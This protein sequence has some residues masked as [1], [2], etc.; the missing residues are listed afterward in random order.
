[1]VAQSGYLASVVTE[2]SGCGAESAPWSLHALPGQ[3]LNVSL[4]DYARV[5]ATGGA[6]GGRRGCVK[7]AYLRDDATGE[8][9]DVCGGGE[10]RKHVYTSVTSRLQ[11]HI[12]KN[13]APT[14]K[15]YFVLHYEGE[16]E[17]FR[18]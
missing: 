4:Y 15:R 6:G 5:G 10:R 18:L 3:R 12:L 7:Y 17:F 16:A 13:Y 2:E 1:M 11:V 9:I 14:G 8:P